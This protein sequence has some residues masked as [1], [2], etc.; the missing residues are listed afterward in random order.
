MEE[1][2]TPRTSRKRTTKTKERSATPSSRVSSPDSRASSPESRPSGK[3]SVRK[4]IKTP[5][6]RRMSKS[7]TP[8]GSRASSVTPLV[9]KKRGRTPGAKKAKLKGHNPDYN[10]AYHY[11]S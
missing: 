7:A 3:S 5:K 6:K 4:V 9:K 1:D 10:A 11:G 2:L 8:A